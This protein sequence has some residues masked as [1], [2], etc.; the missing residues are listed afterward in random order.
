MTFAQESSPAD[1]YNLVIVST[2]CSIAAPGEIIYD[3][4]R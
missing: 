3:R 2:Q 1:L 4:K